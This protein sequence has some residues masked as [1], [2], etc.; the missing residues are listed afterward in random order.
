MPI[1]TK[2]SVR[3]LKKD[4]GLPSPE[5]QDESAKSS[6][7]QQGHNL[8]PGAKNRICIDFDGTIVPWGE[9][10]EEKT[11]FKYVPEIM[12]AL[13]SAGYQIVILT[14][15][16]SRIWYSDEGWPADEWPEIT[17]KQHDYIANVLDSNDIP[18]D[19]ITSEKVPAKYY[20]DDKA[21]TCYR[22]AED[23]SWLGFSTSIIGM[24]DTVALLMEV[25]KKANDE[26]HIRSVR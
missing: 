9:L 23:Q 16:M 4:Q 10:Y 7:S 18:W 19:W 13:K 14:S 24:E 22:G 21:I 1:F 15:R 3:S 8:P 17:V 5:E 26:Q 11:P 6:G 2:E 25:R 12:R 20:F